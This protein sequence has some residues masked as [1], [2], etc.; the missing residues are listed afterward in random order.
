MAR[1]PQIKT[2]N[3]AHDRLVRDVAVS[4][5]FQDYESEVYY[6]YPCFIFNGDGTPS[7]ISA[8]SQ[9]S[10]KQYETITLDELVRRVMEA[11]KPKTVEVRLNDE[12][13]ASV[14]HDGIEVGCQTFPHSVLED[15]RKAVE[16]FKPGGQ[17][18]DPTSIGKQ[19]EVS[20]ARFYG[21]SR[22][23]DERTFIRANTFPRQG[24]DVVF[25]HYCLSGFTRSIGWRNRSGKTLEECVSKVLDAGFKVFEFENAQD[26][27]LWL[28]QK[29]EAK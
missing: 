5:G 4:L 19:D 24:S 10:P 6:P 12:Y 15:L 8:N 13:T 11:G 14:C 27:F 3:Q 1:I 18:V 2:D 17:K 20:T 28:S 21:A 26:F 25:R 9:P 23:G 22:E 29:P 7:R 16:R